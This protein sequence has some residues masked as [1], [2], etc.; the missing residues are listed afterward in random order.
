MDYKISVIIPV[1]NAQNTLKVTINS[2]INQTIGFENIELILVDDC[3]TDNSREI[4]EEYS[5]VYSNIKPIFLE[6]NTGCPGIPRNIGIKNATSDYIMFI[7]NDDEYFPEICDELYDAMIMEDADIVVCNTLVTYLNGDSFKISCKNSERILLDEEITYFDNVTVWNC[8]FKKSI[9]LDNNLEFVDGVSE[10]QIFVL[11][12]YMHSK[13]LVY[14]N[15]FL[16]YHHIQRKSSESNFSLNREIETINAFYTMARI[17][18]K[19]NGDLNRFF[20][21]TI[22]LCIGIIVANGTKDEI[23]VLFS[24]LSD[25]ENKINFNG[26]LP[27]GFKSIN[28]FILHRNLSMVTYMALF[29]SKL[30]KS[31]LITNMCRNF[32]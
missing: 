15:D 11:E 6:E 7:D 25:F 22:R 3:S 10:D 21:D 20:N 13:K 19:N 14:I 31:N 27:I 29:F 8:I 9:I 5:N 4:I 23:K 1:Y 32:Y 30:L 18:E 12:Y 28:Y 17:L 2:V 26:N 24:I 16:G